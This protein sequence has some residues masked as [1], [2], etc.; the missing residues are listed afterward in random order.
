MTLEFIDIN[1]Q[2]CDVGLAPTAGASQNTS[3]PKVIGSIRSPRMP[4]YADSW[5]DSLELATASDVGMR[6]SNNQDSLSVLLAEDQRGWRSRG[7]LFVVADGMG[8]HA[9]GELASRIAAD[10][11]PHH[12]YKH[13]EL[14]PPEAIKLAVEETNEEIHRRGQANSEFHNMGT[15]CSCLLLLP[16]GALVAHVGDSRIYRLR[17][18]RLHQLTFDHSLVWEMQATGQLKAD[19]AHSSIPKNVITRSLGPNA[20]VRVDLEGPFEVESGDTFLIC[21]DGLTARVEDIELGVIL[22]LLGPDEA[23]QFLVDLA[24]VRGGPDN[25]TI[26]IAKIRDGELVSGVTPAD[27]LVVG[28]D[29]KPTTQ[30]NYIPWIIMLLAAL[31]ALGL[32]IA[33]HFVPAMACGAVALIT[34]FWLLIQR[35][36]ETESGIALTGGKRLGKGPHVEFACEPTTDVL[37]KLVDSLAEIANNFGEI[38]ERDADEERATACIEEARKKAAHSEFKDAVRLCGVAIRILLGKDD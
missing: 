26:V 38:D 3:I 12:Y 21:S 24:N 33:E 13:P 37:T 25:C 9:A 19:P 22:S 32:L 16:Q 8:A 10:G 34:G 1:S 35:Y 4:Q 18:N 14:S 29:I 11:V 28:A 5:D 2:P 17:G 36:G 31:L 23:S 20:E 7:H 30:T 15:T 6:R 27:P